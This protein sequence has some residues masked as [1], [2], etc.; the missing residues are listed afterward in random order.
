MEIKKRGGKTI[1]R[2]R[3]SAS[4]L[5]DGVHVKPEIARKWYWAMHENFMKYYDWLGSKTPISKYTATK[6]SGQC[7]APKS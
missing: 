2:L 4:A 6:S 3:I 7:K 1:R 5:V